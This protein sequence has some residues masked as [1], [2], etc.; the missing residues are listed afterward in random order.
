[1]MSCGMCNKWQHI[2]C[3]D[4]ADLR[5]G[6]RK[7]D[8]D[9]EEF[10]CQHCRSR[11]S[12]KYDGAY[13]LRQYQDQSGRPQQPHT[14]ERM[15]YIQ[16]PANFSSSRAHSGYAGA[17]PYS[18]STPSGQDNFR[19]STPTSMAQQRPYQPHS[20]IT[21]AHYQPDPE[22]FST[23]Q[24][25]QRDLPGHSQ[26]YQRQYSGQSDQQLQPEV[27]TNLRPVQV[28]MFVE[29]SIVSLH[30]HD[31]VS[32]LPISHQRHNT[33]TVLGTLRHLTIPHTAQ[34]PV[35]LPVYLR[36]LPTFGFLHGNL[37]L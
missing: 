23:R 16:P 35:L 5:A 31:I 36:N 18:G 3:H 22:G 24:T 13:Q 19:T 6:R 11:G 12:R 32:L 25:Y 33:A 27:A 8:W 29:L 4:S 28:R 1:M 14:A 9:V 10:V 30:L 37:V 20:A 2:P 34:E 7:R 15:T 21:F 26:V 17:Q